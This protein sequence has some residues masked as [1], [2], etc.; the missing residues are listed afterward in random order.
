M[1][2]VAAPAL[3]PAVNPPT[4]PDSVTGIVSPLTS[5]VGGIVSV[6][7]WEAGLALVAVRPTVTV[8]LSVS[9]RPQCVNFDGITILAP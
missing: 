9:V 3:S 4:V 1:L 8:P 6:E 5:L 7:D 2:I